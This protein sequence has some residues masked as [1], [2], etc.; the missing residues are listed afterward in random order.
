MRRL[1][2]GSRIYLAMILALGGDTEGAEAQVRQAIDVLS[3]HPPARAQA[4]ATLARILV[5]AG[6]PDDAVAPATEAMEL[7]EAHGGI[8]E[9][10]SLVRLEHAV[11]LNAAGGRF[12]ARRA[13]LAAQERLLERAGRIQDPAWRQ[14]FLTRV[15]ENARTLTLARSWAPHSRPY[16]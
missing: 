3:G 7:L 15:P 13:I 8:E 9:G 5:L 11:A 16:E 2:G 6:R 12:A 10:E 14:S 1:E 4:L